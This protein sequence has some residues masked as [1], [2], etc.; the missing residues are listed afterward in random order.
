LRFWRNTSVAGLEHGRV[1][2][3]PRGTLGFEWDEDLDNGHRP[4]GLVR[5]SSTTVRV[6]HKLRDTGAVYASGR[7]THHLT[8]HRAPS[9]ALV[10]SAGTVQWSWGLDD[11]HDAP[12][13]GPH[14]RPDARMQQATVNLLVDM[15]VRPHTLRPGLVVT[16]VPA[17]DGVPTALVTSPAPGAV[18][19][20]G[21]RATV[22]GIAAND[23]GVV[24]AVEVSVDNGITWHP[25]SGRTRWRF[26]W[27]P[28][29]AGTAV[30]RVRAA[31]D[32]GTLGPVSA[33]R[34]LAVRQSTPV[35][36]RRRAHRPAPRATS[37]AGER[38]RRR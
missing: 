19:R 35:V 8:L 28:R 33:P 4:P 21:R 7:A 11:V 10:F 5:L 13:R 17:G 26:S 23:G 24:G 22:S 20:A 9:G 38:W 12:V 31:D 6:P 34:T 29:A 37:P 27:V 30:V 18:L 14:P 15:G 36:L 1:A 3:L 16:E 25:A 32:L 2:A